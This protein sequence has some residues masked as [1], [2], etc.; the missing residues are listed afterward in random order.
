MA[1]ANRPIKVICLGEIL[2]DC[3]ADQAGKTISE[4]T[5]WT[6]YPGGAPANVACALAK[7][8]TPSAF[9]GRVGKDPQGEQLVQLLESIGVDIS[10]IQYDEQAPTRKVYVTRSKQGDRTFAG[11]GERQADR[12]ADAYLNKDLLPTELFQEAEYLVLGTL[13]LAYHQAKAA[14]FRA[15]ELA[16]ENNLKIVLDVNWRPMFWLDPDRA[17]PLIQELWQ[18]V[19]FLKLAQEEARWLFNT[20]DAGEICDRLASIEGVL[21]S[22][23]DAQVSYCLRKNEGVV[24]PI[25]VIVKDTTGAGDA[26]LAGFIHQL[27]CYGIEQLS[28]SQTA[29]DIVKYACTVGSLTTTKLGAIAAQPDPDE[30]NA[31]Y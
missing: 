12:F 20:A 28:N 26:F 5:S 1:T 7:L 19:D 25:K 11:F 16:V 3:L 14:I 31:L 15:L 18:Y 8:G 24:E 27:C 17:L 22:N 4:V 23:G 30:I 2:F 9:I 13:E 6:D 21:V 10:G 29:E